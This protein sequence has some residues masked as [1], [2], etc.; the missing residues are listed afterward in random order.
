M[1]R[2]A[3]G[4]AVWNA[5]ARRWEARITLPGH[6]RKPYPMVDDKGKLTVPPCVYGKPD[7]TKD[8]CQCASCRKA[9]RVAALMSAELRGDGGVPGDAA[10]TLNEYAKRWLEEREGRGL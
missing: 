2:P 3:T 8:G 5:T 10:E 7:A 1:P 9:V 6:G 4:S